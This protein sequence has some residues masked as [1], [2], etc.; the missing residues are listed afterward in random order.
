MISM[1]EI[2]HKLYPGRDKMEIFA[3]K[4]SSELNIQVYCTITS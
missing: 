3:T 1:D 4:Q 2:D